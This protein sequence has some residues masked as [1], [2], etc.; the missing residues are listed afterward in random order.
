MESELCSSMGSIEFSDRGNRK[1]LCPHTC[2]EF[3]DP[4]EGSMWPD[5]REQN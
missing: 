3:E 1:D 2:G 5:H 4:A